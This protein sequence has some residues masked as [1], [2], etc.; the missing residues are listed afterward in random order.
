MV[1]EISF[2]HYGWHV[3]P[4]KADACVR[5]ATRISIIDKQTYP[6]VLISDNYCH[7]RH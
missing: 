3:I 7:Y 4:L 5:T 6:S 2:I 1:D